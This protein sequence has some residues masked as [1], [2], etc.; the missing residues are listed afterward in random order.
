MI[1]K[2]INNYIIE[3]K[4]GEGGMGNVYFAR[5]NRVDRLVAIKVLHQNL[6]TNENI[7][8]RFKNEANAL[9]KLGHPNI[10]K[11]Y[12]YVEQ[13][14]FACLVMEYIEGYTLDDYITKISG[15]LVTEKAIHIICNILDAVQYAHDNNILHRDIKPGNIMVSKDGRVVR[16]MDFGIAKIVD[17]EN[18]KATKANTQLGTPFYMSPEQVKGLPYTGLS[19][20]YSLGVTLYEMV[21]GK[22]PYQTITNL[23]ELQ[24]KIVNEP[25]PPTTIYYPEVSLLIQSAIKKATEKDPALRFHSCVEFKNYLQKDKVEPLLPSIPVAIEIKTRKTVTQSAVTTKKT[26]IK[27]SRPIEKNISYPNLLEAYP[28]KEKQKKTWVFILLIFSLLFISGLFYFLYTTADRDGDG[29]ANIDDKC[30][31]VFGL[32]ILNGCPS[33]PPPNYDQ[34]K[35]GIPDSTDRCKDTFGIIAL[36]GCPDN[37]GDSTAN[38]DDKCPDLAGIVSLQGCPDT[39]LPTH[40]LPDKDGDGIA[41]NVDKCPDIAGLQQ[42]KGCPEVIEEPK[43]YFLNRA[44]IISDVKREKL[45]CGEDVFTGKRG[46]FV[47]CRIP[48]NGVQQVSQTI[49][50]VINIIDKNTNCNTKYQLKYMKLVNSFK[51]VEYLLYN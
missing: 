21:T 31:N 24:S 15:P 26:T 35:D 32:D 27:G 50:V 19:D 11:I 29:V 14:N 30:P 46:Q 10:V 49:S 34:D 2:T 43:V 48:E 36:N 41:D 7:R 23:F 51:Y 1:W 4:L 45:T 18:F 13:D 39:T 37:D 5:H 12:D 6:F 44:Q 40:P 17:A 28:Q 22:C 42:N 33:P 38:I 16:I 20:I 9:I 3:R 47:E 8:N 25:L